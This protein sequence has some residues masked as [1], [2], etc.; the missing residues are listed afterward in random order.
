MAWREGSIF[1][2]NREGEGEARREGRMVLGQNRRKRRRDGGK[3]KYYGKERRNREK[4]NEERGEE[5]NEKREG[6]VICREG[7]KGTR[8]RRIL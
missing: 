8:R 5:K 3:E 6:K 4:K 7:R 2:G 1:G